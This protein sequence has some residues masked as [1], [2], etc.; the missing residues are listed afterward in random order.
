MSKE[1]LKNY[2]KYKDKIYSYFYFRVNSNETIAEDL[3]QEVF[4]KAFEKFDTYDPERPFQ[5]WI[6]KIA[7]NHLI[8]YYRLQGRECCIDDHEQKTGQDTITHINAKL[9]WEQVLENIR[10]LLPK[11]SEVLLLRFVDE[12][13]NQEIAEILGEDE[14]TIRTRISRGIKKIKET[15][16]KE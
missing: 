4:L 15:S 1:F 2:E 14:G 3:T 12:L 7:H 8:N 10:T 9:E 16:L 13:S 11:Y 5:S 6:Y